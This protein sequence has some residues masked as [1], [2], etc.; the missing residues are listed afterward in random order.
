MN[1][2]KIPTHKSRY[3]QIWEQFV[4]KLKASKTILRAIKAERAS[5]PDVIVNVQEMF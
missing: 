4:S 3:M 5:F 2:A 1:M